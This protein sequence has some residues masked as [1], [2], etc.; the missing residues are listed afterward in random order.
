MKFDSELVVG[1]LIKRYKRFLA[2]VRL[3]NGEV[4]TAHVPNTGSM[5]STNERG[6]KVALFYNP[7][8]H[9][10]LKW[11][12]ELYDA[13]G[14]WVGVNTMRT[15]H[16]VKEAIEQNKIGPLRGYDS[17]RQEV[18]YGDKSRLDLFLEKKDA[19]GCFVEIK[20]VT[21]KEGKVAYFPDAVT[22]RGLKHLETLMDAQK[23]GYRAV[24]FFL[25]N[26]DDCTQMKP[27]RHIDL[28][29]AEMLETAVKQGVEALAYSVANSLS[30]SVIDKKIPIKLV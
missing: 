17:I 14:S 7:A 16:I 1:T 11:T 21:F 30:Q 4:V 8:P 18:K 24:I 5:M 12:Y 19:P 27:A 29:Y 2:D 28:K 9:R 6:A 20:N 23:K 3:E 26:R 25:V 10:K 15:N 13:A 22:A